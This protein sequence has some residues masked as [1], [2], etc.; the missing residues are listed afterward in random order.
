MNRIL[1]VFFLSSCLT[2][3]GNKKAE[4]ENIEKPNKV[5][6]IIDKKLNNLNPIIEELIDK[7][8]N[9]LVLLFS[10]NDCWTCIINS[11]EIIKTLESKDYDQYVIGINS[12]QD[13][14]KNELGYLKTIYNDNKGKLKKELNY[15]NTPVIIFL[16]RENV[17]LN[18]FLPQYRQSFEHIASKE[19]FISFV[20]KTLKDNT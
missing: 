4:N 13:R 12:H 14:I 9:K 8:S 10:D 5:L 3:C 16:N 18:A 11:F 6:S 20:K 1:L 7:K 19:K 17:V 15:L 2:A